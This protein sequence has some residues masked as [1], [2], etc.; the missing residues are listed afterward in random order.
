[1]A[2]RFEGQTAIIS[3]GSVGIGFATS[4]LLA[5]EGA[6]VA[7]FARGEKEG[8]EAVEAIRQRS[9][10]ASFYS[11]DITDGPALRAGVDEVM[12]AHGPVTVLVN[13]AGGPPR[14]PG[15]VQSPPDSPNRRL[16]P[17]DEPDV[18]RDWLD[19]NLTSAYELCRLVWQPMRE[20]GGGSIVNVSSI[21]ASGPGAGCNDRRPAYQHSRLRRREGWCRGADTHPGSPRRAAQHSRQHREA[22]LDPNPSDHAGR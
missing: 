13:N 11:V 7:I 19:L 21:A 16:F 22:R 18:W 17:E 6:T 3:G 12:K 9:G 4:A 1:M 8:A 14:P 20:A 2:G 5:Q 10:N 15:G